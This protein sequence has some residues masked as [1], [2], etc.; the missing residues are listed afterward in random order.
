MKLDMAVP[1]DNGFWADVEAEML[2]DI[3]PHVAEVAS[4]M[5]H[6][7]PRSFFRWNVS[8]V[9]TGLWVAHGQSRAEAIKNAKARLADKTPTDFQKAYRK[10]F[11]VYKQ[12]RNG[13]C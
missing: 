5:V 6:S 11:D 9:E 1:L 8:N 12:L 7:D 4:F 13:K 2:F 10:A 3:A